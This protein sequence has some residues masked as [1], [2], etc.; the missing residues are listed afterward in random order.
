[1]INLLAES[2]I[3]A[4]TTE[5]KPDD[6]VREIVK[7]LVMWSGAVP[8]SIKPRAYAVLL[9]TLCLLLDPPN[10]EGRSTLHAIATTTMLGLA[11]SSP[12]AFKDATQALPE[13][14]RGRLEKAIRDA[15]GQAREGKV[16]PGVGADRRGIE[17]R[18]FG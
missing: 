14:E 7:A 16:G 10:D 15:V 4:S 18:S 3:A 12:A 17:L 11:Q 1:M 9:P 2:V 8:E 13:G 6:S 5:S